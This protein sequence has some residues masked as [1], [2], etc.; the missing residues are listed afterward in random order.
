[1]L[2]SLANFFRG[3]S[4]G[5]ES[6]NVNWKDLNPENRGKTVLQL[7]PTFESMGADSS[8][9]VLFRRDSNPFTLARVGL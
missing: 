6:D 5:G 8:S 3:I 7:A 4:L 2:S 1:M 9:E